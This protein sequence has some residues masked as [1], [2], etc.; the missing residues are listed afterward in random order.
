MFKQSDKRDNV[1]PVVERFLAVNVR[2][3]TLAT[4]SARGRV[5]F[6]FLCTSESIARWDF[7]VGNPRS[8]R[9][10]VVP[11]RKGILR[12]TADLKLLRTRAG[13]ESAA[14]LARKLKRTRIASAWHWS[15][16]LSP[17]LRRFAGA[18]SNAAAKILL[19]RDQPVSRSFGYVGEHTGPAL[20]M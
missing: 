4:K 3:A 7:P 6:R 2:E 5:V 10:S 18:P 14:R 9:A 8:S 13:R 16:A 12:S 19:A 20:R 15:F 1:P 17:R 11:R